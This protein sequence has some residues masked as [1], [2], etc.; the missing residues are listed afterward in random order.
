MLTETLDV[1]ADVQRT[2]LDLVPTLLGEFQQTVLSRSAPKM[3]LQPA[4]QV[5]L[6][7]VVECHELRSLILKI[8][9][10]YGRFAALSD[11]TP[12]SGV[13][14]VLLQRVRMRNGED[15]QTQC[16][17]FFFSAS[18]SVTTLINSV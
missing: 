3:K 16:S 7:N 1:P 15:P 5:R 17:V 13:C 9:R 18:S 6:L 10:R 2:G 11:L 14:A 12:S 4:Q 8:S